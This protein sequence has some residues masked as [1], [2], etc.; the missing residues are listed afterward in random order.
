MDFDPTD[1][2]YYQVNPYPV[3]VVDGKWSFHNAPIGNAGDKKGT[4]YP[5]VALRVSAPCSEALRG[6]TPDSDGTVRFKPMPAGC[7]DQ[8]DKVNTK[9]VRLVNDGP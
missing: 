2:Y 8:T 9:T 7:P 5:I 3:P 1:G 4:V 6:R